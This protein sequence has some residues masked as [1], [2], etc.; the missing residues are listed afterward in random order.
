MPK[1]GLLIHYELCTGCH[2]C[3]IACKKEHQRTEDEWGIYVKEVE[4]VLNN[5]KQYFFPIPTDNCNLCGKRISKGLQ[6]AC[7]MHCWAG[8]MKFGEIKDLADHIDQFKT[9]LWVP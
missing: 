5:G 2:V 1:F 9:V 4:P 6:P 7:V 3:E 8:V